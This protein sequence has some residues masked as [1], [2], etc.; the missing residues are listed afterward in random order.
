MGVSTWDINYISFTNC[1][2]LRLWVW[3]YVICTLNLIYLYILDKIND[4]LF[5][6]HMFHYKIQHILL[7]LKQLS[8]TVHKF[9]DASLYLGTPENIGTVCHPGISG[10]SNLCNWV[11][12]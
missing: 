7:I 5:E 6:I 11:F 3:L 12:K 4:I 2:C 1:Q 8:A 9:C 10:T